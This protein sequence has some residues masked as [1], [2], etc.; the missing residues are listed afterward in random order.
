MTQALTHRSARKQ[1]NERLEFLGDSVLGMVVA[2]IL[3]AKFPDA[4]EG[5]LTR[6]RSSLVK[7]ETL[8]TIAR[9]FD[10]SRHLVLGSGEMKS[11]DT[12]ATLF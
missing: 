1:H 6:M 5:S 10:L 3:F 4:P 9:E 7:G 8:A 2:D 11:V 12:N